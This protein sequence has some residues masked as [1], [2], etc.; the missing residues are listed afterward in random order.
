MKGSYKKKDKPS[1]RTIFPKRI[2][3]SNHH[4]GIAWNRNGLINQADI[5]Y[6]CCSM[7]SLIDK[8]D[9]DDLY[10][11]NLK[12]DIPTMESLKVLYELLFHP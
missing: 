7:I 6:L 5:L 9:T 8:N 4:A 2:H 12:I 11:G 1:I 3:L 10:P